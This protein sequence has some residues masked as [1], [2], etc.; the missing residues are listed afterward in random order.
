MS[1]GSNGAYAQNSATGTGTTSAQNQANNDMSASSGSSYRSGRSMSGVTASTRDA[2]L[3]REV[4]QA[5]NDKGFNPGPIDGKWGPRTQAALAKFQKAQG[6]TASRK[7]DDQTLAALGVNTPNLQTS[8][9]GS[10]SN[11]P[12]A[13]SSNRISANTS[14]GMQAQKQ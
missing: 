10:G 3:V 1:M 12:T 9:A 6:I 13:D 11:S 4:Q 2:S 14:S 8:Q 5:L 7:L